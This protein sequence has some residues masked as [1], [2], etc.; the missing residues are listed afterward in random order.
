MQPTRCESG[1]VL[2]HL[3]MILCVLE[4][5]H[6]QFCFQLL[7]AQCVFLKLYAYMLL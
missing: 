3:S 5:L 1:R 7:N 6:P 4:K 2:L